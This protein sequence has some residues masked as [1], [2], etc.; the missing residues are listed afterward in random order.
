MARKTY[1]AQGDAGVFSHHLTV[2]GTGPAESEIDTV[3]FDFMSAGGGEMK[4][5]WTADEPGDITVDFEPDEAVFRIPYTQE[6]TLV[7]EPGAL[8]MEYRVKFAG[9]ETAVTGETVEV[10]VVM[11]RKN[12]GVIE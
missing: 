4:R 11:P 7:F 9:S 6:D 2:N 12:K 3:T 10:G 8:T 1:I 5:T